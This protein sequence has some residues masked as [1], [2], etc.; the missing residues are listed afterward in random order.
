MSQEVKVP[1][2]SAE[3]QAPEPLSA[4]P[5][6]MGGYGADQRHIRRTEAIE[7]WQVGGA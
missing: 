7:D 6:R 2:T 1:V 3:V 5:K 4:L